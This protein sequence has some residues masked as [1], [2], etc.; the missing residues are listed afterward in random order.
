VCWSDA[1]SRTAPSRGG[2][3]TIAKQLLPTTTD[4]LDF[5][6]GSHL[7]ELRQKEG[8][9]AKE[10]PSDERDHAECERQAPHPGG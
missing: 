3:F 9:G 1:Y 6:G 2:K 10:K 5:S 7:K 8:L 4:Y